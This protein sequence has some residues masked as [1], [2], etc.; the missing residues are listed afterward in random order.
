MLSHIHYGLLIL[1]AMFTIIVL[2]DFFMANLS[3]ILCVSISYPISS[4]ATFFKV[5][6]FEPQQIVAIL[7][8]YVPFSQRVLAP[9]PYLVPSLVPIIIAHAACTLFLVT[10][11]AHVLWYMATSLGPLRGHLTL[12]PLLANARLALSLKLL[13]FWASLPFVCAPAFWGFSNLP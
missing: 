3:S 4:H 8:Q 6:S 7:T 13:P 2:I 1:F 11:H 10:F 5:W 9:W 12:L